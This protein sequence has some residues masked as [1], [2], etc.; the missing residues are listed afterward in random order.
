MPAA[1]VRGQVE[2]KQTETMSGYPSVEL[3]L[4]LSSVC[5]IVFVRSSGMRPKTNGK[6]LPCT[7]AVERVCN[8]KLY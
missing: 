4:L 7:R 2:T 1:G 3:V 8:E 5:S 6:R